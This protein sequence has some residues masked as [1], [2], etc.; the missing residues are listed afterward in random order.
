[1]SG[2][3]PEKGLLD[4][5]PFTYFLR[6]S[7]IS[8]GV[9]AIRHEPLHGVSGWLA[10]FDPQCVLEASTV[11]QVIS[12]LAQVEAALSDGR[13]V[14][15]FLT[16]E[17]APALD[18]AIE[19]RPT[20]QHLLAWFA[21][22][23]QAPLFFKELEPLLHEV[24]LESESDEW[25]SEEYSQAFLAVHQRLAAGDSYQANLTFRKH[26]TLQH[27]A[28][29][30]FLSRCGVDP[31]PYAAFINGGDW[32]VVSFSPELFIRREGKCVT[33]KPMKG[34][35]DR[36][37]SRLQE[38]A[39][40]KQLE[41]SEKIAAENLMIVDMVRNDLGRIAEVGSVQVPALMEIET[42]GS[43][44]QITSTITSAFDG[45]LRELLTAVFP[46]ASVTG[47]PK[48]KTCEILA[49]V[50]SSPRGVYCGAIGYLEPGGN[51]LF[52]VGIRTGFVENGKMTYGVGGGIV[53]DSQ[54]N[55]EYHE[56]QLKARVIQTK[57][58]PWMLVE[59]FGTKASEEE[60]AQHL[61][62]LRDSATK[63]GIPFDEPRTKAQ[64]DRA[65]VANHAEGSKKVRI[66]LAID[67][68]TKVEV[69]KSL[70]PEGI[71]RATIARQPR[72]SWDP[73]LR[74]KTTSRKEVKAE[75]EFA[76][77]FDEVLFYNERSEITEFAYG[78]VIVEFKGRKLT[79]RSEAGCLAG[80]TVARLI[81]R[82]EV[83][84]GVVTLADIDADTRFWLCNSVVGVRE[85]LV[86]R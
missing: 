8:P 57:A 14:F 20:P 70:L 80:I 76:K 24:E 39:A 81:S 26:V 85:V 32:Q 58:E 29:E 65:L 37:N 59:A 55:E 28:F 78:N 40:R 33:M 43:I 73:N 64:I 1:M 12:A 4:T 47:A 35:A 69:T 34:T 77:D 86:N 82:G 16:H 13:H 53:W 54:V 9:C 31:P 5:E 44:L 56:A 18:P 21:I 84:Y 3:S 6:A 42:H 36:G 17:A 27:N 19:V 71:L 7:D 15:G 51:C 68:E 23:D 41:T 50:E 60:I 48:V 49:N 52:S 72:N 74:M 75:L 38:E 25:S 11:E 66:T 63:L 83:Q 10:F 79:P 62:R 22:Y 67:G 61:K 2:E 45:S 30:L 46:P